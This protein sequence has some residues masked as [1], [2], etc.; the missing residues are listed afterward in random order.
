MGLLYSVSAFSQLI[1]KSEF[2]PEY[3]SPFFFFCWDSSFKKSL[4]KHTKS[5]ATWILKRSFYQ[6]SSEGEDC[7]GLWI[8]GG[9]FFSVAESFWTLNPFGK[10]TF[11]SSAIHVLKKKEEK[12]DW[13]CPSHVGDTTQ[14]VPDLPSYSNTPGGDPPSND[15][16]KMVCC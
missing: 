10:T 1:I 11:K 4:W 14:R 16:T 9:C 13:E 2:N 5:A 15:S 12:N 7:S 6:C 3:F 8:S